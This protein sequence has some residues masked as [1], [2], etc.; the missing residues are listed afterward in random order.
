MTREAFYKLLT[1]NEKLFFAELAAR[2][3]K[4]KSISRKLIEDYPDLKI[5]EIKDY[6]PHRGNNEIIR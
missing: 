4:P 1:A 3:G 2:F 5:V 6:Q